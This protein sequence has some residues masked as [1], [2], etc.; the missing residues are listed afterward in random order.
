[1][2]LAL[3]MMALAAIAGEPTEKQSAPKVTH[4][5][6][7]IE[8]APGDWRAENWNTL[9]PLGR[10]GT[11]QIWTMPRG[12]IL[13]ELATHKPLS[14]RKKPAKQGD[15]VVVQAQTQRVYVTGFKTVTDAKSAKS[16][17]VTEGVSD[18]YHLTVSAQ[19]TDGGITSSVEL[20]SSWIGSVRDVELTPKAGEPTV[21]VQMP[22][23]M[24]ADVRGSWSIGRNDVLVVSVGQQADAEGKIRERLVVIDSWI[25]A[26]SNEVDTAIA[27][28]A[29]FPSGFRTEPGSGRQVAI[30]RTNP[31]PK[32]PS[33][34]LLAPVGPDGK[35]VNLPPL[36]HAESDAHLDL[37]SFTGP[38]APQSSP[39]TA[40][41]ARNS[42]R[43]SSVNQASLNNIP[44]NGAVLASGKPQTV[45]VSLGRLLDLEI[46]AQ[47]VPK[48]Q[49]E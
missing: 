34:S 12:A 39:Q 45:R 19:Q 47:V 41:I 24:T 16:T 21:T 2:N 18:G 10:Q 32:V 40:A 46:H 4:S 33:R 44:L 5:V 6:Q 35:H 42:M 37:A 36:P 13:E 30:L 26:E 22:Q 15:S 29:Y 23:V 28:A 38:P 11:S 20:H 1:M 48:A 25:D 27:P 49:P 43:D 9:N 14:V 31:M 8:V 3:G 17:P 7:T